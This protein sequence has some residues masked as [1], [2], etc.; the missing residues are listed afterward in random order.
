MLFPDVSVTVECICVSVCFF[1]S[2]TTVNTQDTLRTL[3]NDEVE[4]LLK[5][6]RIEAGFE[7]PCTI[8]PLATLVF[9][10]DGSFIHRFIVHGFLLLCLL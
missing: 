2:S 7:L 10:E 9:K 5:N 6:H 3:L 8:L 4:L 1:I